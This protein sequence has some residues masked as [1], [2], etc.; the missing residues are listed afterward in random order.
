MCSDNVKDTCNRHDFRKYVCSLIAGVGVK[1]HVEGGPH[2]LSIFCRGSW[3]RV[4]G[5]GHGHG[6]CSRS[7]SHWHDWLSRN[8]SAHRYDLITNLIKFIDRQQL[9]QRVAVIWEIFWKEVGVVANPIFYEYDL[10]SFI[11]SG[12]SGIII[13]IL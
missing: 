2:P 8:L 9:Q 7:S 6:E 1:F 13:I 10:C 11:F 3:T 4:F 5:H 12:K